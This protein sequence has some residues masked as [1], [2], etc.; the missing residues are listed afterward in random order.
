MVFFQIVVDGFQNT[1]GKELSEPFMFQIKMGPGSVPGKIN[2][3]K[4]TWSHFTFFGERK[5][6]TFSILLMINTCYGLA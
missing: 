5:F 2:P 3:F 6:Q 1:V 4:G